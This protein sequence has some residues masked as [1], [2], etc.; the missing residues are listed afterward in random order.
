LPAPCTYLR[1]DESPGLRQR[2]LGP[3]SRVPTRGPDGHLYERKRKG[4]EKRKEKEKVERGLDRSPVAPPGQAYPANGTPYYLNDFLSLRVFNSF[5]VSGEKRGRGKRKEK[6]RDGGVVLRIERNTTYW[7]SPTGRLTPLRIR[8]R[9]VLK[10]TPI[11]AIR[12]RY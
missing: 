6:K 5:T 7:A 9:S 11:R 8:C 10:D 4:E 1:I 12:W 3:A 2:R